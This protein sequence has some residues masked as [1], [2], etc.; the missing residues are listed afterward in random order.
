MRER[1]Y[2]ARV[3]VNTDY[4]QGRDFSNMY[5]FETDF[6]RKSARRMITLGREM[7]RI[8]HGAGQWADKTLDEMLSLPDSAYLSFADRYAIAYENVN[9]F[10]YTKYGLDTTFEHDHG[11]FSTDTRKVFSVITN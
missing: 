4:V 10:D 3:P 2:I 9:R 6:S 5:V 11:S 1:Q 7:V 8:L